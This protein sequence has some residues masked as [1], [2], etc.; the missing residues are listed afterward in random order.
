MN[1][2]KKALTILLALCMMCAIF[3]GCTNPDTPNTPG[4]NSGEQDTQDSTGNV[5]EYG[6]Y[7]TTQPVKTLEEVFAKELQFTEDTYATG[8]SYSDAKINNIYKIADYIANY[9]KYVEEYGVEEQLNT[10]YEQT[11]F[12]LDLGFGASMIN[13]YIGMS[14]ETYEYSD[15]MKEMLTHPK[16]NAAQSTCISAAMKAAEVLVKDGQ[17]GVSVNQTQ[18]MNFASLKSQDGTIYYALGTYHAMADL[19]NVQRTG[20]TF[21]A[22]VTFRILD[23]YDWAEE[24]TEPEFT[25][26]LNKLD[27]TYRTLLAEMVDMPTLEGFCQADLAQLHYA[28]LAQNFLAH[29]TI[30]YNVTWTAGQNFDQ[31]TVTP[32]Q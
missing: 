6:I 31:A 23:Y 29:G 22:T 28:G 5:T 9:E 13:H 27:D 8:S 15:Q 1:M 26:Y 21:S 4:D 25:E 20:N 18:P 14:G 10:L 12:T 17:S 2:M 19:S 32:A 3:A 16:V 30:V 7:S 11:G 24:I